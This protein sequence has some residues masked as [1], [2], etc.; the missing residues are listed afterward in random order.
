MKRRYIHKVGD[1]YVRAN[2]RH[3]IVT[4]VYKTPQD[5]ENGSYPY[6]IVKPAER[7]ESKSHGSPKTFIQCDTFKSGYRRGV[8]TIESVGYKEAKNYE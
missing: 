3:G 2:G 6:R 4:G 5:A 7:N 1:L 8:Y